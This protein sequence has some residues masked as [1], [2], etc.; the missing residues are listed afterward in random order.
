MLDRLL[1]SERLVEGLVHGNLAQVEEALAAKADPNFARTDNA[2]LMVTLS[3]D[4][5]EFVP[6][7][8]AAGADVNRANKY[9][10]R[11]VHE[12]AT[13]GFADALRALAAAPMALINIRAQNG[14]TPMHLAAENGHVSAVT[15]LLELKV[16]P[17]GRNAKEQT[18]LMLA[19]GRN[20]GA[21]VQALLDAGADPTL[22]DVEGLRAIDHASETCALVP[23]L[24]DRLTGGVAPRAD[25]SS[26][27]PS[28]S[29]AASVAEPSVVV[30][31]VA[32]D[33]ALGVGT[34]GKRVRT[35]R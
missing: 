6:L 33:A 15:A 12:A 14:Q 13:R 11:A 16:S 8:I 24:L 27:V 7:L 26:S 3:S 21:V 31:P 1:P 35:V 10:W 32:P 4:H 17:D 20:H 9:G 25:R 19:V 23:D 29:A 30:A 2:G 22:V 34:I 5:P 28:P 18:P